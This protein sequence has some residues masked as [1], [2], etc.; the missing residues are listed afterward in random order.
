M[1]KQYTIGWLCIIAFIAILM[2]WTHSLRA[3]V[4]IM[5]AD[6]VKADRAQAKPVNY[7][8]VYLKYQD[9]YFNITY[10]TSSTSPSRES[11]WYAE[12]AGFET[13][14]A[15]IKWLNQSNTVYYDGNE[16]KQ[17][18]LKPEDLIGIYCIKDARKIELEFVEE[19]KVKEKHIEIQKDE[20]TNTSWRLK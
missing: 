10:A 9:N 3:Q 11:F 17:A 7:V 13:I 6:T 5:T 15:V 1:T 20:W 4:Y 19:K 14:D 12:T 2:L 18:R 16:H 8:V